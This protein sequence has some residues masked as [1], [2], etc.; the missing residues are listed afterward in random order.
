MKNLKV[1][2]LVLLELE[3]LVLP[4]DKIK[5]VEPITEKHYS[6]NERF[7]VIRKGKK[8]YIAIKEVNVMGSEKKYHTRLEVDTDL[9]SNEKQEKKK[10]AK[11][12]LDKKMAKIGELKL[13]IKE[14]KEKYL[15]AKK[16]NTGNTR[17]HLFQY[18][19]Y[20]KQLFKLETSVN[21]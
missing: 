17:Y 15:L 4:T 6:L 12:L 19:E 2:K 16:N 8:Y 13:K 11:E 9:P 3:K 10:K 5:E 7:E 14:H 20:K 18:N 21:R 1:N